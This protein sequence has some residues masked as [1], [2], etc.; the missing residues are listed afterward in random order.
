MFIILLQKFSLKMYFF[1]IISPKEN[2]IFKNNNFFYKI[3]DK[4]QNEIEFIKRKRRINDVEKKLYMNSKIVNEG[5]LNDIENEEHFMNQ[6]KK[7]KHREKHFNKYEPDSKIEFTP[8]DL[9][10]EKDE[11]YF[12]K[13]NFYILKKEVYDPWYESVK[14]EAKEKEIKNQQNKAKEEENSNDDNNNIISNTDKKKDKDSS[15]SENYSRYGEEDLYYKEEKITK[16]E[17]K[18]IKD[19]VKINRIKLI[20]LLDKENETI[21]QALKRLKPKN[22]S[23]NIIRTKPNK[24]IN[25]NNIKQSNIDAINQSNQNNNDDKF[26]KLLDIVSKLT[27]LSYFEVYSDSIEKIINDYGE[28][29]IISFK[30]KTITKENGKEEIFGDFSYDQM[31]EWIKLNYFENT[32]QISFFFSAKD[33]RIDNIENE[34]WFGESDT[35]YKQYFL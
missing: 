29:S 19:E 20:P 31:K 18:E 3:M 34:K 21:S 26:N 14:D 27:E 33:P 5:D 9:K 24:E 23:N 16:E 28:K 30:Y 15:E 7:G 17:L 22:I 35:L 1:Y 25:N 10:E 6:M 32:E 4:T 11:G 8:F 2:L 12:D 13:D